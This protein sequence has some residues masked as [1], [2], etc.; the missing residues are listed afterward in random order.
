MITYRFISKT[1]LGQAIKVQYSKYDSNTRIDLGSG[2]FPFQYTTDQLAGT[3]Y[4]YI[5]SVDRTFPKVIDIPPI[6]IFTEE[7]NVPDCDISGVT[8]F[9]PPCDIDYGIVEV[10]VCDIEYD[11][12][13]Q[14][15]KDVVFPKSKLKAVFYKNRELLNQYIREDGQ[16]S[17][18]FSSLII[19]MI[20]YEKDFI[21]P[22]N[23][24]IDKIIEFEINGLEVD[25]IPTGYLLVMIKNSSDYEDATKY[26]SDNKLTVERYFTPFRTFFIKIP[27]DVLN[28]INIYEINNNIL[29][30][31]FCK[32]S[33]LDTIS[34][35]ELNYQ[36]PYE[37]SYHWYL[38]DIKSRE[39]WELM[40][41]Q[42]EETTYGGHVEVAMIDT[43]VD[44]YH[45]ELVGKI[46]THS[47]NP[48]SLYWSEIQENEVGLDLGGLSLCD[49]QGEIDVYRFFHG[50]GSAGLIAASNSNNDLMYSASNDRVKIQVISFSAFKII[51]GDCQDAPLDSYISLYTDA[52]IIASLN[53]IYENP[54]CVSIVTAMI[55]GFSSLELIQEIITIVTNEG[56][57]GKGI[58]FFVSSGNDAYSA[59]DTPG[60]F[61]DAYPVGASNQLGNKAGFSQYGNKLFLCAP[62]EKIMSLS[63]R[64]KLGKDLGLVYT[65]PKQPRI[66]KNLKDIVYTNQSLQ[67]SD[68]TSS[69]A[70][71]VA[72]IAAT[73]VYVNP[74]LTK[75]QIINILAETARKS[76]GTEGYIYSNGKNL[77]L[78]YGIVDHEE[79]I[80]ESI[81]RIPQPI[82]PSDDE[83]ILV[84]ILRLPESVPH[85]G[86][87]EIVFEITLLQNIVLGTEYLKA[88][89]YVGDNEDSGFFL[90]SEFTY[91]EFSQVTSFT[92]TIE[93][94]LEPFG[95]TRNKYLKI[96]AKSFDELDPLPTGEQFDYSIIQITSPIDIN[97]DVNME[98]T[99]LGIECLNN[100]IPCNQADGL[101]WK[102]K[103]LN[104]SNVGV[105]WQSASAASWALSTDPISIDNALGALGG[106]YTNI[107]S[108]GFDLSRSTEVINPG[109]EIILY[110]KFLFD[111][112]YVDSNLPLTL[113]ILNIEQSI[114]LQEYDQLT[115]ISYDLTLYRN[116]FTSNTLEITQWPG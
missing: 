21:I 75:T 116:Q 22:I 89:I 17:V 4:F 90:I 112:D 115:G 87:T 39:A 72:A 30:E 26:F 93:I 7:I 71:I 103:V 65:I 11:F 59:V 81:L 45:P 84:K 34:K 80:K 106:F 14:I 64:G 73:M 29:K 94:P 91:T 99:F 28:L 108:S 20:C 2:T 104:T 10:P 114:P 18:F 47:F 63:P 98:L 5:P 25:Y 82:D 109:E 77:Q 51:N 50:T 48:F 62:G 58:P 97:Y 101:A 92:E 61:R 12:E 102:V 44:I 27:S 41:G 85:G 88:E 76:S 54:N 49:Q 83:P 42:P 36:I 6:D 8:I 110:I 13:P 53:K 52:G 111:F 57:N 40:D 56:R 3:F 74:S 105:V 31:N 46:S 95:L 60:V 9:V 37:S 100:G 69:S 32:Y 96:I 23:R 15:V 55:W 38:Q 19:S 78:G 107:S 86:T 1:F 33:E 113:G 68:G 35:A 70:P 24:D 67:V 16:K 66:P 43:Q 79:A